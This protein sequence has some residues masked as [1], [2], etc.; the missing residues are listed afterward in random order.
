MRSAENGSPDCQY[1]P[2][3][4]MNP[5]TGSGRICYGMA[6]GQGENAVQYRLARAYES[7][8]GVPVNKG[9]AFR[10]YDASAEAGYALA[11]YKMGLIIDEGEIVGKDQVKALRW[12]C[13]ATGHR[14]SDDPAAVEAGN[15]ARSKVL[16]S[17]CGKYMG[18]MDA[19]GDAG[20]A[21]ASYEP[22]IVQPIEHTGAE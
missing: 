4:D 5:G 14:R 21:K 19:G 20:T 1:N 12:W 10:L 2:G 22:A 15:A 6:A 11:Q 7:G 17:V 9:E 16:G 8:N 13:L 3:A 18:E